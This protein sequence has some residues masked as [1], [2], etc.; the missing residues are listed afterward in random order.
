VI[1]YPTEAVWGIGCDPWN[2]R[3]VYRLLAIKQRPVNKGLILVASSIAQLGPLYDPLTAEQKAALDRTWPGPNTWLIPDPDNLVPGWIKGEHQSVAIRV[4]AHPL[5]VGLCNRFGGMLVSTS[6]NL[7]GKPEIRS[8][9]RLQIELGAKLDFV[10]P[11][12]LGPESEP[13]TIRD[14]ASGRVFR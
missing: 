1:A 14:L 11:G 9:L 12:Q 2:E 10:V 5:V 7:A 13:S 6:A 3:A 8:R 4:S